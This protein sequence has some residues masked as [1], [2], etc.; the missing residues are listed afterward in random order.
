MM[1]LRRVSL[2][3]CIAAVL[4]GAVHGQSRLHIGGF[5]DFETHGSSDDERDRLSF[6]QVDLFA[7]VTLSPRWSALTEVVAAAELQDRDP[8]GEVIDMDL[9]RL[10]VAC[11]VSDAFHLEIGQT[12]TGIIRWNEREHRSR[13]LQTPIAVPAIARRPQDDGV[14]PSRFVGVWASGRLSGPLGLSY[15]AGVGAGSGKSRDELPIFGDDRS[16]AV[17]LSLS[18]A[19][20]ALPGLEVG[21]AAYSQRLHDRA[22]PLRERDVTFSASYV[23]NGTEVR[24][25]WARMTHRGTRTGIKHETTGYYALASKRLSG[26][27]ERA[28]PYILIDRLRL[29]E[30]ETYFGEATDENAW[31]AGLRYDVT[32]R[33]TVKGEVRSQRGLHDDREKVL[34][35]Q[36]GLAF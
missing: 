19:P 11:S 34:G 1:S 26:R 29:A 14:W 22:E 4:A 16:A 15:G 13:F 2:T 9:E 30:G 28:R 5:G 33:W 3:C 10:I 12:H 6:L 31:A 32:K 25:E 18:M 17:L 35:L 21:V 36:I 27:F 23:N 7:T 24:A 20:D 8:S